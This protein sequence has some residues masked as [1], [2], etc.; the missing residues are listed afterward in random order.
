[1]PGG[2]VLITAFEPSGDAL[3]ARLIA[4]LRR[5]G[6]DRPVHALGGPRMRDAGASLIETT[7]Q[8]PAML[9]SAA[10]QAWDHRKRLQRLARWL[11]DHP[12]DALVPTDSPAANF[13]ICALVRRKQPDARIVHLVAPQLWAWGRWRVRKLRRLTDRLLCLLPF[14]PDWFEAR[15]VPA[16]FVGHPLFEHL[17]PSPRSAELPDH[18]GPRLALLPGSRSSEIKANWPTMRDALPRLRE[19]IPGLHAAVAASDDERAELIASLGGGALPE[20]TS[21]LVGDAGAVLDWAGSALIVSGTASLE[22]ATRNVPMAVFYNASSL[23]WNTLGKR[24]VA[25]RTFALPNIITES[26]G[27]GRCVPELVPHFGQVPPV[28]EAIAPVLTDPDVRDRQQ[29]AFARIA[30]TFGEV[31][32]GEAATRTVREIA[33][34]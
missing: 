28:V 8:R 23:Q 27:E 10:A 19:S 12:I 3:A 15:G 21:M 20:Q 7:T 29:Q 11:D 26:L 25:A 33:S 5:D 16:T 1:M 31:R 34:I 32:F 13:S 24:L 6:C 14:E 30:E 17:E 22:A 2:G 18:D 4:A 9:L